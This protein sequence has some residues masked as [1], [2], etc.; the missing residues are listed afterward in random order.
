MEGQRPH[1]SV[2]RSLNCNLKWSYH[3]NPKHW[4]RQ[5][6]TNSVDPDQKLQNAASNQG[7]HCLPLVQHYFKH[8]RVEEKTFFKFSEKIGKE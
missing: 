4:D 1:K 6:C 3:N 2:G 7:L 5:V 8:Q